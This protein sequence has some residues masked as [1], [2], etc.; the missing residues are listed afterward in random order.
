ML[1]PSA[2]PQEALDRSRSFLESKL[3]EA[4]NLPCDLPRRIEDLESWMENS[5]AKAG[6]QYREYLAA[7][8]AGQRRRYF[9]NK[10]HALN[11]LNAVAPTKL[12]DGS[13]LYGVLQRWDDPRFTHLVRTYL[14]ELGEGLPDKNHVVLY[15]KLLDAHGCEDYA[16]L[17]DD[18]FTQGAIQLCLAYHAADFLPE[19]IGFNLGYEQLP[20][21]LLRSGRDSCFFRQH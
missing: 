16:R 3:E 15:R 2:L 13:W 4:E 1:T 21:H 18:Y 19:V 7:R 9:G 17:D 5:A 14:E 20:L 11:F 10:S 8:R 12:A 6:R